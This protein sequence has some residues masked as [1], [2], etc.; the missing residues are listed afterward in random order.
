MGSCSSAD[1]TAPL[2][3]RA[4]GPR[5]HSYEYPARCHD[6]R[7]G[8]ERTL[9]A[10]RKSAL[11]NL[12][13]LL[14]PGALR[15]SVGQMGP[16]AHHNIGVNVRPLPHVQNLVMRIITGQDKLQGPLSVDL[17]DVLI[18]ESE[19]R[20]GAGGRGL[21]ETRRDQ[22]HEIE[23]WPADHRVEVR[24]AHPRDHLLE[25]RGRKSFK[26]DT[27]HVIRV[28]VVSVLHA[29]RRR[30]GR[31]FVPSMTDHG[32]APN[33]FAYGFKS[34]KHAPHWPPAKLAV[35]HVDHPKL[36]VF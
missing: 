27:F 28:S 7:K 5:A 19:K 22:P 2:R 32:D 29:H 12:D 17:L 26:P 16:D 20:N 1:R 4:L 9:N 35:T 14:E 33:P 34:P 25:R 15:M 8:S 30:P 13:Q 10:C 18:I 6:P 3:G 24:L 23:G 11:D 36:L 21:E 31:E